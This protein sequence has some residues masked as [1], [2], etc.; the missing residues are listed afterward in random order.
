M[1]TC[2]EAVRLIS[3]REDR[4]LRWPER[5]GLRLHVAVCILCRRYA[6]Q[7]RYLSTLLRANTH[8]PSLLP[9]VRLDADARNRIRECL[10]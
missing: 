1:L 9:E 4:R 8:N 7:I 10:K 3:E 5:V 2:K 6:R